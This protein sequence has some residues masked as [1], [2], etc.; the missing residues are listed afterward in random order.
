MP[1]DLLFCYFVLF[2]IFMLHNS[3]SVASRRNEGRLFIRSRVDRRYG[4]YHQGEI[5][6]FSSWDVP[7]DTFMSG[8]GLIFSI[9]SITGRDGKVG[10]GLEERQRPRRIGWAIGQ[11]VEAV[12]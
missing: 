8:L 12:L 9:V 6:A 4:R 10:F 5:T 2:S 3:P 11:G 7:I 1:Y